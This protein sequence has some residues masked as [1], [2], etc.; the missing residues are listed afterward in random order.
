[1]GLRDAPTLKSSTGSVNTSNR[2]RDSKKTRISNPVHE[3]GIL[4]QAAPCQSERADA[5]GQHE[6]PRQD[7]GGEQYVVLAEMGEALTFGLITR[8]AQQG[9]NLHGQH[10]QHAG[11]D[12]E[13]KAS[14]QPEEQGRA[15]GCR[16][17]RFLRE[18]RREPPFVRL[19][20]ASGKLDGRPGK[21]RQLGDGLL[22]GACGET[23]SE[24]AGDVS[25]LPSCPY[26]SNAAGLGGG[27]VSGSAR[28]TVCC[29][30]TQFLSEQR[31]MDRSAER[32]PDTGAS[33]RMKIGNRAV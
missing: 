27:S 26:A 15:E 21:R 6:E 18:T 29:T 25:A 4:E 20:G 1:M 28:E 7:P 10:G 19:S 22:R 31:S 9:G 3:M 13:D 33:K 11:H 23:G 17:Q 24:E 14:Q 2:E 16:L 12:I 30:G 5:K 8:R 32:G